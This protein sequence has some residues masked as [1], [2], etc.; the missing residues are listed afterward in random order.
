MPLHP[1]VEAHLTRLAAVNLVGLHT[2]SPVRAR[3]GARRL[4]AASIGETEPVSEVTDRIAHTSAG[5]VPIRIYRPLR[6]AT[7]AGPAPV[8]VF[9][10]GGGYVL[11]DLDSHDALVRSI[12]NAARMTV[13]S[14]D[15]PLAPEHKYPAQT[16]IGLAATAW[17][18]DHAT[19]LGV[20]AARLTVAGDSAGGNLA[21]VVALKARD[22]RAP[23]IAFQLLIYPDLDFRREN[24]SVTRFAG[25]YG[26]IT[27][28]A[29]FWFM[30]HYL[31]SPARR[32]DRL[33]PARTRSDGTPAGVHHHRG[34]RRAPGRRRG[35]RTAAP[36]RGR[37][38]YGAP[39]RRHDPRVP[40]PSVRRHQDR[41]HGAGHRAERPVARLTAATRECERSAWRQ[42]RSS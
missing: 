12:T 20:D 13:I 15:Y 31:D 21:A 6:E 22:G 29:Q 14:V 11:G 40:P 39:L 18:A 1:Q 17:V 27:R 23:H 7:M 2:V 38:R 16:G 19:E 3:E 10:H 34:V 33:T 9:F 36:R 28:E 32:L 8:V 24:D 41:D 25:R 37:P 30:D 42:R 26:N 5:D 4:T 35:I